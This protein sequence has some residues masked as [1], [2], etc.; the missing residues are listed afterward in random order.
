MSF[1]GL[2]LL[3]TGSEG[4]TVVLTELSTNPGTPV[5]DVFDRLATHLFESQII[6][7]K[8]PPEQIIWIENL[9]GD[10][11]AEPS[12]VNA[13]ASQVV[14][15]WDGKRFHSPRRIPVPPDTVKEMLESE[16]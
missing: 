13:T 3:R 8:V 7:L 14:L 16:G 6:F 9:P 10:G 12:S 11:R 5:S 1:C 4:M 15:E 2:S